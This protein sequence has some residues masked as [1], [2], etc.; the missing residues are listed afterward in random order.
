[1][2]NY[3]HFY[4]ITSKVDTPETIDK[5]NNTIGQEKIKLA[6]QSLDRTWKMKQER[7]SSIYTTNIG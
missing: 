7:L 3:G 1:M 6:N 5:L 4:F 2:I